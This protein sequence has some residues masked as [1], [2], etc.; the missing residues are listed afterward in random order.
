MELEHGAIPN[1]P[2]INAVILKSNPII[3]TSNPVM[4]GTLLRSGF[5]ASLFK[6][7]IKELFW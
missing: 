7:S 3:L 2:L 6:A 5:M 1:M 4:A